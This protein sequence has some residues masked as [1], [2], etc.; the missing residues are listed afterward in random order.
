MSIINNLIGFLKEILQHSLKAFEEN[1]NSQN[2]DLE[3]SKNETKFNDEF[4]EEIIIFNDNELT[5]N[6][7]QESE[8]KESGDK[9]QSERLIQER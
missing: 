9:I 7:T 5:E 3:E 2:T 4:N 6:N 8:T 1:Q